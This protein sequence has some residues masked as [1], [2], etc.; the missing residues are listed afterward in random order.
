VHPRVVVFDLDGTLVDSG[1]DIASATNVA[2]ARHGFPLLEAAEVL[3]YVG[4]GARLLLA[5]AARLD[6][7]DP[8]LEPLL[9][10]F[11]QHYSAHA[12]DQT[13]L[14]PGVFEALDALSGFTLA[15][16]TNKPRKTSEIVVAKLGLAPRF[17]ELIAGGD[18]PQHKPDPAPLHELAQRFNCAPQA[19]VMVGDGPQDVE[20]GRRAGARTVGVL[21][22]IADPAR[23]RAAEPDALIA[24][25][26][27][28]PA[29]VRGWATPRA[30]DT[31]R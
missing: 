24:S 4:D 31:P 29:L 9:A 27:E 6:P 5:R 22:G 8:G 10:S 2:L 25:L 17:A 30:G 3:R 21:G 20:C 7:A 28:L 1:A 18:L 26:H 11:L 13:R 12:V 14:L 19:L 15:I 16:C 23:L